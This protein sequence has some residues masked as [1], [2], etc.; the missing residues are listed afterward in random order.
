MLSI[1]INRA[2][3]V[4]ATVIVVHKYL[5]VC[6]HKLVHNK[7]IGMFVKPYRTCVSQDLYPNIMINDAS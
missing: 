7:H 3:P 1:A 5:L 6:E 4:W 2:E